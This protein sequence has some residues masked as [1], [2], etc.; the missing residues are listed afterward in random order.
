ME[1]IHSNIRKFRKENDW[2]MDEV[3]KRLGT[4]RQTIQRYESGEIKSIPYDK[5]IL[6]AKLFDVSPAELMGY[7]EKED[8]VADV[9]ADIGEVIALY[10]RLRPDQ[11]ETIKNLMRVFLG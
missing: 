8:E 7:E 5:I 3:A 9:S 6:L 1:R 2:T 10:S 11:Q 4:T